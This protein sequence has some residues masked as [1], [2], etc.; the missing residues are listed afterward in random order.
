MADAPTE[1]PEL[2]E[3][4]LRYNDLI[5][6]RWI[7][8]RTE[9]GYDA[10]DLEEWLDIMYPAVLETYRLRTP[11]EPPGI[12]LD[13]L[14]AVDTM[15]CDIAEIIARYDVVLLGVETVLGGIAKVQQRAQEVLDHIEGILHG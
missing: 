13:D 9:H 10:P 3:W 11:E 8:E 1:F 6:N 7:R 2:L 15:L 14:G 5:A 12:A 4:L